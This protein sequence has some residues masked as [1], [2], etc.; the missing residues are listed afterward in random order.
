MATWLLEDLAAFLGFLSTYNIVRLTIVA[1]IPVGLWFGLQR[2]QFAGGARLTAWLIAVVLEV[3]P[4]TWIVGLQVFRIFGA[5]FVV[6]WALGHL[7]DVFLSAG[8]AL[9]L[10]GALALPVAFCLGVGREI[11]P[12]RRSGLEHLRKRGVDPVARRHHEPRSGGGP[13]L[14]TPT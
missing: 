4:P 9:V 11:G 8:I 3:M 10:V 1:A 2:T 5:A 6:Q 13:R 12:Y 14:I 7:P